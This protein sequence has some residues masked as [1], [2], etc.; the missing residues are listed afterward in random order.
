[1]MKRN[2]A[3]V[4]ASPVA[5]VPAS[6]HPI[7]DAWVGFSDATIRDPESLPAGRLA[8]I[9]NAFFAGAASAL[10]YLFQEGEK[11]DQEADQAVRAIE[12]EV[13]EFMSQFVKGGR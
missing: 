13:R 10:W 6:P 3:G 5:Q 7:R 12:H 8:D 4:V 9:R 11:S 1:M 2:Y